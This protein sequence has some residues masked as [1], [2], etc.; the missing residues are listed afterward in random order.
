MQILKAFRGSRI[1]HAEPASKPAQDLAAV[2][3]SVWNPHD[4]PHVA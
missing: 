1:T 4:N 2:R 3:V